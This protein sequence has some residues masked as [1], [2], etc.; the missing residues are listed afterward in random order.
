MNFWETITPHKTVRELKAPLAGST[1]PVSLK[2]TV[3]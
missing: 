2:E 1:F 3:R